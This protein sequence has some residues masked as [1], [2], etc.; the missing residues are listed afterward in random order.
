MPEVYVVE[1][2]QGMRVKANEVEYRV[3]WVGWSTKDNTWEPKAH[4]IEYGAKE[5]VAEWHASN[6]DKPD[7]SG[8]AHVAE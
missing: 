5:L 7:P 8:L 3:K 4:L 1:K 6:P 2:I